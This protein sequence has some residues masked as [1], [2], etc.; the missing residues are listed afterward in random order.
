MKCD[1]KIY[2]F[3]LKKEIIE[4]NQSKLEQNLGYLIVFI[5]ILLVY[6]GKNHIIH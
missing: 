4:E 2:I 3:L 1:E 5:N 6:I